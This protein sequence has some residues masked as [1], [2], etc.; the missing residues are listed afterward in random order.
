VNAFPQVSDGGTPP[1]GREWIVEAH[2][3]DPA[4]LADLPT[5]QGLFARMVEELGLHPVAEPV[6][7]VF[8]GPGGITGLCALAESHLA[9]HTFPEH[10]SLCLNLFCCTPRP[11]WDYPARLRELLGAETVEVRAVDRPYAAFVPAR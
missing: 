4:A 6:W 7:H 3:C 10:G 5:L 8:P 9:C 11:E 2:G 1:C